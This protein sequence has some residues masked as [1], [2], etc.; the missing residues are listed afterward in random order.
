MTSHS[1][2]RFNMATVEP[3]PANPRTGKN[4]LRPTPLFETKERENWMTNCD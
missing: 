2:R 1:L 4:G 3:I